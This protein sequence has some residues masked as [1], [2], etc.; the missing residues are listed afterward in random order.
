MRLEYW[1]LLFTFLGT[2]QRIFSQ[3]QNLDSLIEVESKYVQED[4]IRCKLLIDIGRALLIKQT[5]QSF[6]YLDKAISLAEKLQNGKLLSNAIS[7]KATGNFYLRKFAFAL[8]DFQKALTINQKIGNEQGIAN[9]YNNLGLVYQAT[10][11]FPKSLDCFLKTLA[12]N[13]K[14]GNKPALINVLGNIG[15]IY[16]ELGDYQKAKDYGERA[17]NLL[18]HSN[19]K[20]ALS[21][22]L[23]NLGNAY[24]HLKEYE[25]ALSYKMKSLGLN[26]E[27][28]DSNL[29]ATNYGNIGNVYMLMKKFEEALL[30]YQRGLSLNQKLNNQKGMAEMHSGLTE[31][32]LQLEKYQLAKTNALTALFYSKN[33][34]LYNIERDNLLH[35]SEI[36]KAIYNYDSAYYTYQQYIEIKQKIDNADIQKEIT[37]ITLLFDFSKTEDSL[38]QEQ[39]ITGIKLNEQLLLSEKQ[40]QEIQLKQNSINLALKEREIQKIQIL[41]SQTDLNLSQTQNKIKEEKLV[42]AEKEKELQVTLVNL[43]KAELDVQKGEIQSQKNQKLFLFSGFGLLAVL[44]FSIYRNFINQKKSRSEIEQEKNKSESLLHNILPFEVAQ[45]LKEK[46]ETTAKRFNEVTV[47]FSDFVDFTKVAERLSPEDL[48]QELH[49]CFSQFDEIISQHGLEKIK[50]IGDAYMAVSGLPIETKNHATNAANA[51]LKIVTFMQ[52]RMQKKSHTFR[53]R[54][55]L[56]S[57]PVVAGVVGVKKF[58]YDI[59]GDTVNTAARM[60]TASEPDKINISDTTAKHLTQNFNLV[61]RGRLAVKNKGEIEMYFLEQSK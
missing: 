13:E 39:M 18:E 34:Q 17:L 32:Y 4:T 47:L 15:N 38:R 24:T 57:G 54:L 10:F 21:G 20:S 1:M 14:T 19:N 7:A 41:K 12:I 29:I 16:F 36:Y 53:I 43:Q 33:N 55:G 3:I 44:T 27:A 50:T 37:K 52:Q 58:A 59:W 28:N 49:E 31:V 35:L 60:E 46:G 48:V 8:N 45:E 11:Q 9:N 25:I 51:A 6:F 23:T 5:N 30:Y 22:I 2:N 61:H 56:H 42:S 40:K 26:Q